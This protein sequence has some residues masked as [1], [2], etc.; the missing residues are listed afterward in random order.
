MVKFYPVLPSE[1]INSFAFGAK[2]AI[3][4]SAK[5]ARSRNPISIDDKS[6]A[7]IENNDLLAGVAAQNESEGHRFL[8]KHNVSYTEIAHKL[9]NA[10][11]ENLLNGRL[12]Q[13]CILQLHLDASKTLLLAK[14][15]A[16][17][18]QGDV[19]TVH[20]VLALIK[21]DESESAKFL[22]ELGVNPT[23]LRGEL[24]SF[25]LKSKT[26]AS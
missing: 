8:V 9:T 2:Q 14:D 1:L 19:T 25:L 7:I 4:N 5:V 24:E 20:I 6:V 26:K 18:L 17:K 12:P 3:A 21:D 13:N 23:E 22:K 11:K 15:I 10:P 16:E